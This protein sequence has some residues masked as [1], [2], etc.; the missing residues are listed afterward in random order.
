MMNIGQRLTDSF[1]ELSPS[2]RQFIDKI[3]LSSGEVGELSLSL[4]VHLKNG[5]ESSP[6]GVLAKLT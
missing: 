6:R 3:S 4:K 1:Y 2:S 5:S